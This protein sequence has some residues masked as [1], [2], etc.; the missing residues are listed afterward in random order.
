MQIA[1]T[2]KIGSCEERKAAVLRAAQL[3]NC[4]KGSEAEREFQMLTDAIV[5]FDLF[6]EASAP[7]EIPPGFMHFMRAAHQRPNVKAR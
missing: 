2:G 4:A 3:I 1:E 7:I 5:E 6:Q